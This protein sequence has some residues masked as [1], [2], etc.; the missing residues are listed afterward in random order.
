MAERVLIL[1]ATSG[2]A[3]ALARVMAERGV[4][5]VLAGRRIEELGRDAADLGIRGG[6][7]AHAV[8]FEALDF[9]GHAAFYGEAQK[10]AG[11]FDGVVL[12]Y[13]YMTD[14]ESTEK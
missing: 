6:R 10:I 2:I 7:P 1:G 5:L 11:P 3:R 8:K 12:A 4:E 14:Q 13:G 9:D